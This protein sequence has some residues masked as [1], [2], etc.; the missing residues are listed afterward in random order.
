[1]RA[2]YHLQNFTSSP[3][4]GH[5]TGTLLHNLRV[6]DGAEQFVKV[7]NVGDQ[8][9]DEGIIRC[10]SFELTDT[11]RTHVRNSCYTGGIDIHQARGWQIHANRFDGFWCASGL[12]EHAIHVWTG[13]RDTV[14]DR[15]VIINSVRGIGFGL[16]P[17]RVGR[18]YSDQP[19]S[20]RPYIGHYDG[21]ITNNFVFANDPDLSTVSSA[22]IPASGS[23]RRAAP[24]SCTI[25]SFRPDTKLLVDRMAIS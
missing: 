2:Y 3:D 16:E 15:N 11:G 14:V 17:A 13:S 1:M 23:S 10:S 4:S 8:Y 22:S 18:T 24:R 6:V 9:V 20:N 7:N 25:P 5:I 12:S 21:V 19:C